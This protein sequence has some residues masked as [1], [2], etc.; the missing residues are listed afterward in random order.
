MSETTERYDVTPVQD[1]PAPAIRTHADLELGVLQSYLTSWQQGGSTVTTFSARGIFHIADE[2]NL[3]IVESTFRETSD[4]GGFYFTATAENLNT[5]RRFIA[6]V[7]QSAMMRRSGKEVPDG[8]AIAKGST[9]VARNALQGL[10]PVEL[11]RERV[12]S[13]VRAGEL[14]KSELIAAQQAARAKLSERRKALEEQFGLSPS[15][16]FERAQAH[17][18]PSEL[19]TAHEWKA[20]AHALTVLDAEWW[21]GE[22]VLS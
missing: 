1:A 21:T 12:Q 6:H 13:A 16:T 22:A 3:S 8:D 19:W 20:F 5:G 14:E 7:Y 17:Q 18:G 2:L 4:G 9:R 15:D 11:L 10:I